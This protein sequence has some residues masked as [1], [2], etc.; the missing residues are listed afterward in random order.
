M[1]CFNLGAD[2]YICK[3]FGN[4]ELVARVGAVLRRSVT[5]DVVPH[6]PS[7]DDGYLKIGFAQRQV[8]VAGAE[9]R[10]TPTEYALLQELVVNAGRV[11]TH[12]HLLKRVWGPEY[13]DE[14]EYLH[15]FMGRLRAKI[16]P[17]LTSRT[18]IRTVPGVGYQWAG[19]I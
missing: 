3:P 15:V 11:L 17:D 2:D 4:E 8:T 5:A 1:K 14:K 10:L 6:Q 7:Y 19:T 9:V 13:G 12:L 16:G 18:Y